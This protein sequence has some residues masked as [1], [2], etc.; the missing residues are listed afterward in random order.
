MSMLRRVWLSV[1]A[2]FRAAGGSASAAGSLY[3]G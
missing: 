1:P 2:A 3:P